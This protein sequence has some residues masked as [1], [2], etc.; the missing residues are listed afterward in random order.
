M[1]PKVLFVRE[2]WAC[3]PALGPSDGDGMVRCFNSL[4]LGEATYFYYDEWMAA[5]GWQ[6]PDAALT[7][8]WLREKPDLVVFTVLM[9]Y[10]DKNVSKGV[11]GAMLREVPV[12]GVWHEGVAPDVVRVA[13]EYAD[14]VSFNLFLDT[15]DQFTRH[16]KRPEK[17]LGLFDPR[18]PADFQGEAVARD[19]PVS[20]IGT[21]TARPVRC[22]H[23]HTLVASGIPVAS[24]SGPRGLFWMGREQYATILRRSKIALNFSDAADFR[25]YKGRVA[26]ATLAGAMLME[27]ENP[28]T[29]KILREFIDYVPFSNERDLFDKVQHYLAHEEERAA[30]AASGQARA[31]EMLDGREFWKRVFEKAGLI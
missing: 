31:R 8:L 10:G 22:S 12:V 11:Y 14:C 16:T 23:V 13:D 24:V 28:E 25:H 21:L 15:Q 6:K 20:F 9:Q 18:D 19:I 29:P 5:N 3:D 1:K 27:L 17:C 30:I 7:A 2:K 26:E 4:G